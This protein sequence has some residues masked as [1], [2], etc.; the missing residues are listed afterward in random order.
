MKLYRTVVL[1]LVSTHYPRKVH[2]DSKEARF[3]ALSGLEPRRQ[4]RRGKQT[5]G[6]K[7]RLRSTRPRPT[8]TFVAVTNNFI[9][10]FATHWKSM[11]SAKRADIGAWD[12]QR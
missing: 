3:R 6:V 1:V 7:S 2:R 5:S 4:V 12:D 8:H 9:G 11:Q 10:Q